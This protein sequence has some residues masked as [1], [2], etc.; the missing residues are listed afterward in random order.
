MVWLGCEGRGEV[1][2]RA[3]KCGCGSE[4]S[5]FTTVFDA[6]L[7]CG[8]STPAFRKFVRQELWAPCEHC[9]GVDCDG[10][11]VTSKVAGNVRSTPHWFPT[12]RLS[13]LPLTCVTPPPHTRPLELRRILIVRRPPGLRG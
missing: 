11:T 2:A 4:G 6:L 5:P 8:P 12:Q 13:S 3:D 7:A 9:D 10:K 1:M